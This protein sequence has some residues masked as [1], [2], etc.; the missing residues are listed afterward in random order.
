MGCCPFPT[1]AYTKQ[2][3]YHTLSSVMN[4]GMLYKSSSGY[5][6]LGYF[7]CKWLIVFTQLTLC[8]PS[9]STH[10]PQ[11]KLYCISLIMLEKMKMFKGNSSQKNTQEANADLPFLKLA[12]I[13]SVF[14]E[15]K[16]ISSTS[17]NTTN[18]HINFFC[19]QSFTQKKNVDKDYLY[20]LCSLFFILVLGI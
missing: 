11:M 20:Y 5:N 18:K 16:I 12:L 15:E 6:T 13:L 19:F 8:L 2:W 9:L 14:Y 10:L 17:N 1:T 7:R 3:V 4:E